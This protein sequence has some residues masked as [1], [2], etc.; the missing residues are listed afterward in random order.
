MFYS[1][2]LDLVTHDS[3]KTF[4]E[5]ITSKSISSKT[6]SWKDKFKDLNCKVYNA[7]H[8]K[9]IGTLVQA[10]AQAEV[11]D[12]LNII[13]VPP[14]DYNFI[15]GCVYKEVVSSSGRYSRFRFR[16]DDKAYTD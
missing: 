15:G 4:L 9:W 11:F 14:A 6:T 5:V 13:T 1:S 2:D 7:K 8:S 3:S 16:L 10:D 12:P